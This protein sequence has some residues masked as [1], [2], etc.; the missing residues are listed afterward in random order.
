M[1][2]M[3]RPKTVLWT[4]RGRDH[5]Q[6]RNKYSSEIRFLSVASKDFTNGIFREIKAAQHCIVV[7]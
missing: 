6:K 5:G 7:V 2:Y 4:V 3:T 1:T